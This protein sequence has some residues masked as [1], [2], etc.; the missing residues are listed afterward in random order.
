MHGQNNIKSKNEF[1]PNSETVL[2]EAFIGNLKKKL[3]IDSTLL[4]VSTLIA[5]S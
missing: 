4:H 3:D 5:S 2:S 1:F